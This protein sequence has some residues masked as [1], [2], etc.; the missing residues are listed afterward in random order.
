MSVQDVQGGDQE[1]V[2]VLL[3]VA[4]QVTGVS[5]HQVE[6]TEGDVWRPVA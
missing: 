3:L 6:K 5:P 4:S 1:L 2:G